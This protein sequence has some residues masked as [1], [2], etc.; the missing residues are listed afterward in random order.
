ML[1][2]DDASKACAFVDVGGPRYWGRSKQ[3]WTRIVVAVIGALTMIVGA[4][5]GR[6]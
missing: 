4:Y 5:L 1:T 6:N 2:Q 3:F